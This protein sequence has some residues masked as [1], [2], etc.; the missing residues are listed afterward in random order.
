MKVI[1]RLSAVTFATLLLSTLYTQ[2]ANGISATELSEIGESARFITSVTISSLSYSVYCFNTHDCIIL[3]SSSNLVT[4][5]STQQSVF[6]ALAFK[7]LAS[8]NGLA[9]SV[10]S[11][12]IS[13]IQEMQQVSSNVKTISVASIVG[14][15]AL[16]LVDFGV[17]CA[18]VSS[19]MGSLMNFLDSFDYQSTASVANEAYNQFQ[20][21]ENSPS[22]DAFGKLHAANGALISPLN[23]VI[24]NSFAK[25]SR[26]AGK[27]VAEIIVKIGNFL[28]SQSLVYTGTRLQTLENDLRQ[29]LQKVRAIDQL[30]NSAL[31][32]SNSYQSMMNNRIMKKSSELT[33]VLMSTESDLSSA[34]A[35]I[36]NIAGQGVDVSKANLLLTN[37]DDSI[38]KISSLQANHQYNTAISLL[39]NAKT[40]VSKARQ[41][42]EASQQIFYAERE[43]SVASSAIDDAKKRGADASS[44]ESLN[45]DANDYL[46]KAKQEYVSEQYDQAKAYASKSISI[47]TQARDQAYPLNGTPSHTTSPSGEAGRNSGAVGNIAKWF[48]DLWNSLLKFFG[49]S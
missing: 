1:H 14:A 24:E 8:E 34:K 15:C 11:K 32:D 7:N 12:I 18:I 38:G 43:V 3:D 47:A 33:N 4:D 46:N 19:V 9:S 13:D 49:M 44:V 35:V 16:G 27:T 36:S 41:D 17:S 10:Y 26:N 2:V 37:V 25:F 31:Q 28:G 20:I 40:S 22:Y 29:D 48:N 23:D 5:A 21:I 39:D 6:S 30:Y 42:A 45:K